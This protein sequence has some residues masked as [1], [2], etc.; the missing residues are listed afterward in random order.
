MIYLQYPWF[1]LIIEEYIE[2]EDLEA[3][4][5]LDIVGLTGAISVTQL[6]LHRADRLDDNIL[7]VMKHAHRVKTHLIDVF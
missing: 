2:A 5:V 4:W 7:D 3:H 6:R 1:K